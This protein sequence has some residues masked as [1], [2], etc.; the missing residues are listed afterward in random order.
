MQ[1]KEDNISRKYIRSAGRMWDEEHAGRWGARREGNTLTKEEQVSARN[2]NDAN[3]Y[4]KLDDKL[5]KD[6]ALRRE[7]YTKYRTKYMMKIL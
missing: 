2:L 6:D 4:D 3:L 1:Q 5:H 7:E